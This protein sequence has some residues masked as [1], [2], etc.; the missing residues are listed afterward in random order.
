MKSSGMPIVQHPW[1]DEDLF[2]MGLQRALGKI[3]SRI[4]KSFRNRGG[5]VFKSKSG[6]EH[7]GFCSRRGKLFSQ[8]APE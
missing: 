7:P 1:A 3:L 6:E 8:Q 4:T 2:H 5:L